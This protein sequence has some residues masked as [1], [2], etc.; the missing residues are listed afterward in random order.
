MVDNKSNTDVTIHPLQGCINNLIPLAGATIAFILVLLTLFSLYLVNSSAFAIH[1]TIGIFSLFFTLCPTLAISVITPTT[2]I[3]IPTIEGDK[4][5]LD[6][7]TSLNILL[8]WCGF[9]QTLLWVV[10][11]QNI[12]HEPRS[13]FIFTLAGSFA[14]FRYQYL[15]RIKQQS[16]RD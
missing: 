2:K 4:R 11:P 14:Y 8:I 10:N 3:M 1:N 5:Q 7:F 12:N 13:V 16:K 9:I 6:S 15:E